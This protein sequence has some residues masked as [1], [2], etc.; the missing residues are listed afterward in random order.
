VFAKS[1]FGECF[2][3]GSCEVV[4]FLDTQPVVL[5][6]Q[7]HGLNIVALLFQM[8]CSQVVAPMHL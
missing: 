1:K 5:L 2:G 7:P 3:Q 6:S 8:N 4:G